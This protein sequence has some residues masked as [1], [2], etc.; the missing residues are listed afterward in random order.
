MPDLLRADK[1]RS[2]RLFHCSL[3]IIFAIGMEYVIEDRKE[4]A[5]IELQESF[6]ARADRIL[7]M[8]AFLKPSLQ[9][10]QAFILMTRYL[11]RKGLSERCWT[12]VGMAIRAAQALGLQ[13]EN[14]VE[15]QGQRE[16]RIRTWWACVILDR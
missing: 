3:N 6:F 9:L 11:Q 14:A 16:E 4:D 5:L 1:D 15:S 13:A 2:S 10:V 8:E 7:S 12:V